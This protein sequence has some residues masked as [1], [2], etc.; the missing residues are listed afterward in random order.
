VAAVPELGDAAKLADVVA[1]PALPLDAA[2]LVEV[3]D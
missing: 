1:P 2:V 3:D